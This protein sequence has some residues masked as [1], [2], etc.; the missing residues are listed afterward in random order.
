ML[1]GILFMY[2]LTDANVAGP[3]FFFMTKLVVVLLIMDIE[4]EKAD[5][6]GLKERYDFGYCVLENKTPKKQV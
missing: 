5:V 3:T 2:F 6:N 1:E 4:S